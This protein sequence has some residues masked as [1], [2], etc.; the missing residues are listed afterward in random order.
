MAATA[1]P[2]PS[3]TTATNACGRFTE[4]ERH[5]VRQ[6]SEDGLWGRTSMTT[7]PVVPLL[8]R[9]VMLSLDPSGR[10]GSGKNPPRCHPDEKLLHVVILRSPDSFHRDDEETARY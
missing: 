6:K 4:S 8:R 9:G 5:Q 2:T 10:I 7:F 1:A 3:A